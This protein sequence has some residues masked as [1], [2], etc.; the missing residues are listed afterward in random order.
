MATKKTRPQLTKRRSANNQALSE[1]NGYIPGVIV[2]FTDT[3]APTF[4]EDDILARIEDRK[5]LE[6]VKQFPGIKFRRLFSSLSSEKLRVLVAQAQKQDRSYKP[7]NFFA[8]FR[9]DVPRKLDPQKLVKIISEWPNVQYVYFDP[10]GNEPCTSSELMGFPEAQSYLK[11]APTGIDAQFAWNHCGTGAGQ[12]FIDLER[13]WDFSHQDLQGHFT[14]AETPLGGNNRPGSQSHGTKVLGIVCADANNIQCIGITP[15]LAFAEV[16]SYWGTGTSRPDA[17][18]VAIDHLPFGGVLLLEAQLSL[19]VGGAQ[20]SDQQNTSLLPIEVQDATFQMIRLA[21]ALGI[22]VVEAGGNGGVNFDE[23]A[24][25]QIPGSYNI[26]DISM[27]KRNTAGFRDSGAILVGAA[28]GKRKEVNWIE[29]EPRSRTIFSNFGARVDCFAWGAG[30]T[31]LSAGNKITKVFDG[32]SSAAAIVAGAALA[33]QSVAEANLGFRLDGWQIRTLLSS[34][35]TPSD[36]ADDGIGVMPDLKKIVNLILTSPPPGAIVPD[37]CPY[38]KDF[39]TDDGLPHNSIADI[40]ASPDITIPT[41]ISTGSTFDINLTV[42]NRGVEFATDVLVKVFLSS[43]ASNSLLKPAQWK[44]LG[45]ATLATVGISVSAGPFSC[46]GEHIAVSGEYVL[47]AMIDK[48]GSVGLPY[49]LAKDFLSL[50]NFQ[51]FISRNIK[52]ACKRFTVI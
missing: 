30:V 46:L 40:W 17:I 6:I 19:D 42:R 32:T 52:S 48:P 15:K 21:T 11:E 27:L 3:G 25:N 1:T 5:W 39:S 23:L 24:L 37:A 36:P 10:P 47:I 7:V 51:K 35:G 38:F 2:K 34:Q 14:S 43:T 9:I 45:Q 33:V 20:E 50:T 44:L 22:T 26:T 28:Y 12:H 18:S 49:Y 4:Y 41:T 13:G 16:V 31:T 29:R 8:Y